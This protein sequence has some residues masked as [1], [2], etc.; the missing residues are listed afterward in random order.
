MFLQDFVKPKRREMH[1][2]ALEKGPLCFLIIKGDM[3]ALLTRHVGEKK[4]QGITLK[5]WC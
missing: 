1:I 3:Q 2:A 5:K 4:A